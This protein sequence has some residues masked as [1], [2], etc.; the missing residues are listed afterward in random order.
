MLFDFLSKIFKNNDTEYAN[1][2]GPK[3]YEKSAM[4]GLRFMSKTFSRTYGPYG[5]Y[6]VLEDQ[7]LQHVVTRDGYTV[8]G[9]LCIYEKTARVVA[10][11]VQKISNSLNEVVGDGTT[12]AVI[13][14]YE[15][16]RLKKLIKKYDLAPKMLMDI[17]KHVA[18]NL[19]IPRIEAVAEPVFYRNDD[20]TNSAYN[21]QILT[22]LASIC[23]NNDYKD[24]KLI[25][26][27]FLSLT[28]SENGFIN[29]EISPNTETYFDKDRGFEIFRGLIMPEMINSPD[30]T[31]SIHNEPL[32]LLVKGYLGTSDFD[33]L[34]LI[35]NYAFDVKKRPLVIIA[36]GFSS[37]LR[38][39]L[40]QTMISYLQEHNKI[41][42][43]A[44]IEMD[45]ESAMGKDQL[46]DIEANVGARVIVVEQGR[47]LPLESDFTKLKVYFGSCDKI[48]ITNTKTRFLGGKSDESKVRFRIDEIDGELAKYQSSQHEESGKYVRALLRRKAAL[49]NDMVTLYVGGE[50]FEEKTTKSHL[51]DDAVR[52][53]RSAIN[54]GIVPGGN[55]IVAKICADVKGDECV[56]EQF[57]VSTIEKLGY[58]DIIPKK[59]MSR[60]IT[61]I[62]N[63]LQ[64][65]YTRSYAI[66]LQNRFNSWS[67]SYD[68]ASKC[69]KDGSI[70]N[71]ISGSTEYWFKYRNR[72]EDELYYDIR[73][74]DDRG[75]KTVRLSKN[76]DRREY[77]TRMRV[78]NSAE[79][80][81][82]ILNASISIVDLIMTSNQFVRVP[83][84]DKMVENM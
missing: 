78:V 30:K 34:D 65:A 14:A 19:I 21:K 27:L 10:K 42:S 45:T 63:E 4:Q 62:V 24:G 31:S 64:V 17:V 33:A 44:C 76:Y 59:T 79:I 37:Q 9:N 70:Y 52:G 77:L 32:I 15:L 25:A 7:F 38:D 72:A 71:V 68:L 69:V 48:I 51:F 1:I 18:K 66:V 23:L 83:K 46:L 74:Q 75:P 36:G 35:I 53:C 80:D 2:I 67:Y 81:T 22:N 12:S 20:E 84:R 41:M 60:I 58:T 54:H 3:E 57:A 29:V 73:S 47:P 6:S 49:V 11:L 82:Q 40:R 13:E 61:D 28:D 56:L 50:T 8:F 16:Y 5:R 55:T 39:V 26:D 43:L